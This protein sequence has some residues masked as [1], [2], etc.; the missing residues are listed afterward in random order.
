MEPMGGRRTRIVLA[1]VFV[2]LRA[3][4]TVGLTDAG[5]AQDSAERLRRRRV[6]QGALERSSPRSMPWS[7]NARAIG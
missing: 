6:G 7:A 4:A 5:R 1:A 3:N 2:V